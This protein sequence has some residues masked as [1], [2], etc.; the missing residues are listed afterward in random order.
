MFSIALLA[1]AAAQAAEVP[2]VRAQANLAE[3]IGATDYPAA[4][5]VGGEEGP[6]GF[7]LSVTPEGRI[8]DCRVTAS[9]GSV[10]LDE[11]T[12]R[13]MTERARFTPARD[14][15][16]NPVAD[17]KTARLRWVLPP[18]PPPVRA[19]GN[20]PSF[21]RNDDYP[22]FA[23]RRGEQGEVGFEIEISPVGRVTACRVLSS[24]GS[25][26]LDERTC[27][28]MRIRARFEPARDAQ[29]NPTPDTQS[30]RVTWA[31]HN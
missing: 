14:A 21:V 23:L 13:L 29:G 4:A 12:C 7:Q 10:L 31:I 19:Q 30:A 1:L 24:S 18:P 25:Y 9:S 16:G 28:L 6:V 27:D 5:L 2:P 20:I 15:A 11:T 17:V 3:Y 8:S 26:D 22:P